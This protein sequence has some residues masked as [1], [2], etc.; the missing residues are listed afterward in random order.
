M[1][2]CV[3]LQKRILRQVLIDS[4]VTR[5]LRYARNDKFIGDSLA[6]ASC[7]SRGENDVYSAYTPAD[8]L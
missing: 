2:Q 3:F 1:G 8:H 4:L 5:L 6:I 7:K